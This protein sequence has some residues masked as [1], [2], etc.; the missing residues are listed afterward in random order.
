MKYIDVEDVDS[1]LRTGMSKRKL[2]SLKDF[3]IYGGTINVETYIKKLNESEIVK[4][5]N[6]R[7]VFS[8]DIC[9]I[10]FFQMKGVPTHELFPEEF[11]RSIENFVSIFKEVL[12]K[13]YK[14]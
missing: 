1:L 5:L 8:P 10:G 4:E 2:D 7:Y 13:I 14:F 3:Q 6:G 9:K 12:E 11:D